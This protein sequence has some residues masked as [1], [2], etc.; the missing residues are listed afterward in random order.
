MS[1]LPPPFRCE[2]YV[3]SALFLSLVMIVPSGAHASA[4]TN[5]AQARALFTK[6]VAAQNAHSVSGVKAMLWNSPG[7]A[8]ARARC[9]NQRTR[10]YRR[11]LSRIL[12]RHVACR[13]RY[14][15]ISCHFDF[16]RRDAVSGPRRFYARASKP[17][18]TRQQISGH[19]DARSRRKRLAYCFHHFDREHATQVVAGSSG[20]CTP[21]LCPAGRKAPTI[22]NAGSRSTPK[23][24]IDLN[25]P[26]T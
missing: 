8:F 23:D 12:P 11:S 15:I 10:G 25:P 6:F 20:S 3:V 18:F 26:S 1:W 17:P 22:L 14:V 7:H 13:T 16:K 21:L 5:E 4:A 9:R 2:I 24:A 19:P